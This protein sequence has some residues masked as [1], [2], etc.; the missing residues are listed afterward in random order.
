MA[1]VERSVAADGKADPVQGE[2]IVP[3]DFLEVAVRRASGSHI[4]FSMNL[5]PAEIRTL[6]EDCAGVRGLEAGPGTTGDVRP[7]HPG[8]GNPGPGNLV[9]GRARVGH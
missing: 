3:A 9:V 4:V 5:E 2:G 6:F 8:V 7:K 1:F